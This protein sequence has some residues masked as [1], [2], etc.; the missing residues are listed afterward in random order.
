LIIRR[1][2]PEDRGAVERI[3]IETG[4]KGNLEAYFCD[5]DLFAKLWLSPFLDAEPEASWIAEVDG[6]VVGYLVAAIRPGFSRRAVRAMLPHLAKLV[7]NWVRGQ[8]RAHPPSARF[9]RWLLFRSWR[10]LPS[11]T[12]PLS[13]F[14]FN[15]LKDERG[16][17]RLGDSLL[18]AYFAELRAR[19]HTH[20]T[21]HVF[22]A[23]GK[24]DI[25]FY[26]KVAFRIADARVSSLFTSPTVVASLER[27]IPKGDVDYLQTRPERLD[28]FSVIVMRN[29]DPQA[30]AATL[31][32]IENQ[33]LPAD[34]VLIQETL[35]P[36]A[37]LSEVVV[38]LRAGV[39]A[40]VDLLARVA[41]A[42]ERGYDAGIA[43]RRDYPMARPWFV[44]RERWQRHPFP[45]QSH[46]RLFPL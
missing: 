29:G 12:R 36:L 39:Q 38:V 40:R 6:K 46:D 43:K 9:A 25:S 23:A 45:P 32:S 33:A 31:E 41:A 17:R 4:L 7:S 19:G 28:R 22:G 35:D 15:V 26:R 30:E 11:N 18:N 34:E 5:P 14:H 13:N 20:F 3:C 1:Y 21:I 37:T 27:F 44:L 24:R 42:V 10:E 8:Y 16:G 2:R